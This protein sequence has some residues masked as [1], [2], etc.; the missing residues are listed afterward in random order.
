MTLAHRGEHELGEASI[1]LVIGKAL[2][3][4]ERAELTGAAR[5]DREDGGAHLG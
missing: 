4:I 3:E 2:A 1:D 5:D